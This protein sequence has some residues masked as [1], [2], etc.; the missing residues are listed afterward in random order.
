MTPRL[1]ALFTWVRK[2]V[3]ACEGVQNRTDLSLITLWCHSIFTYHTVDKILSTIAP[4]ADG[5]SARL[6]VWLAIIIF[7]CKS[8]GLNLLVEKN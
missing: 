4:F 7:V 2:I 1:N 8:V 5:V 3:M 6:C